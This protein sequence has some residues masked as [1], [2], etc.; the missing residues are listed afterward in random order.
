MRKK[1]TLEHISNITPL[2]RAERELISGLLP[3]RGLAVLYGLPKSYK[4][5]VALNIGL[6]IS[7]GTTWSGRKVSQ[8]PVVYV[9]AEGALGLKTRIAAAKLKIAQTNNVPF[10][11]V[12]ACPDFGKNS[13]DPTILAEEILQDL[14]GATPSLIILD[15]LARVL[16]EADENGAGMQSFIKNAEE[17]ADRCKC[18][19]L[20][21]HH[22][23]K[24]RGGGLRGHSSLA[25]AV[26][27]NWKV[28]KK[29]GL[30]AQIFIEASKDNADGGFL[31]AKLKQVQ[32]PASNEDEP[33]TTLIVD[34]V[35]RAKRECKSDNSK[36]LTNSQKEILN[37]IV[38]QIK[39]QG[40]EIDGLIRIPCSDCREWYADHSPLKKS[41]ARK[42][43]DRGRGALVMNDALIET[44][45]AGV[46]Y[47]SLP[48]E[49][50]TD[51]QTL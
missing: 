45:I 23:R 43:F 4:S 6:T 37:I 11:L 1:F 28:Q 17:L 16:G 32:L 13:T 42:A 30:E 29:R 5:F 35:I 18:L 51:R 44:I 39:E 3:S 26:V 31:I 49:A 50:Q 2:P 48:E 40:R 33:E 21:V 38:S 27:A 19:V 25:G 8:G 7:E 9:A 34:Q 10:Y 46:E 36:P 24:G 14:S 12:T 15:T 47:F 41:S 20:A 22:E